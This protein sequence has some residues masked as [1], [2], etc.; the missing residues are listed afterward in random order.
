VVDKM[1]QT[2]HL[3]LRLVN[4]NDAEFILSL[5][6]NPNLN[7]YLSVVSE[8]LAQQIAWINQYK[9]REAQGVD[10]Y[11]VVVDKRLGDLGVVR[12]YDID[13]ATCSFTWGSWILKEGRPKY[14]ALETAILVYE[15]AFNELGMLIAKFDVRNQNSKVINFHQRFGCSLLKSSLTDTFF[16]LTK[17]MYIQ[18]KY[19]NYYRFLL[20]N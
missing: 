2:K 6:L 3:Y 11:F 5:R 13:Y 14:A 9:Q 1:Q 18:L 7:Q 4:E 16:E 15:F 19:H 8:D 12:V 20:Q 17:V 10:Y